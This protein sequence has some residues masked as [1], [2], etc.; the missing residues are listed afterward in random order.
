MAAGKKYIMKEWKSGGEMH[1]DAKEWVSE[2]EFISSEHHF[3]EDLLTKYFLQLSEK[4]HYGQGKGLVKDLENNRVRN[5]ALLQAVTKHNN[6][7]IV[8]LD[9]KN[10][11]EEED[12]VKEEHRDMEE[13]MAEHHDR[14][15]K[16]K[17]HTFQLIGS[18]IQEIRKDHLLGP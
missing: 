6:R 17:S 4:E 7:L 16:L 13:Q 2:L 11:F 15:R 3:F 12:R 10:D 1:E 9:G 8:L 18:I 5:T 14:F